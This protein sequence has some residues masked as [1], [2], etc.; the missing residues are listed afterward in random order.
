MTLEELDM[1]RACAQLPIAYCWAF[2]TRDVDALVELFHADAQ[3]QRPSGDIII[4][5]EQIRAS[6]MKPLAGILRHVASNVLVTPVDVQHATGKS[7]AT[8]YRATERADDAPPMLSPPIHI[9][10]YDDHY[11]RDDDG[12]WRIASRRSR[13]VFVAG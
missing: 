13:K 5:R 2:D 9:V 4:G 6:F 1:H 3:W 7:L 8:V 10:Q 11:R 12:C